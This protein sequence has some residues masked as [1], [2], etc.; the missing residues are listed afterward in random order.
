MLHFQDYLGNLQIKMVCKFHNVPEAFT[1]IHLNKKILFK[2]LILFK[3]VD[4]NG[5]VSIFSFSLFIYICF[6]FWSSKKKFK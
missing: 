6:K 5:C 1:N 3:L 2:T 4:L